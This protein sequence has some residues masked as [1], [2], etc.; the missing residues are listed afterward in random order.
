MKQTIQHTHTN[1][2]LTCFGIYTKNSEV[3]SNFGSDSNDQKFLA[4]FVD[5]RP[6]LKKLLAEQNDLGN[7]PIVSFSRNSQRDERR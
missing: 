6:S 7:F 5:L 2:A 4:N 3:R 1:F